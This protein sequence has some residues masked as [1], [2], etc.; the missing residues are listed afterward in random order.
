MDVA[1]ASVN[2]A[3][4]EEIQKV[5]RAWMGQYRDMSHCN[6]TIFTDCNKLKEYFSRCV[7]Q[8]IIIDTNVAQNSGIEF[9]CELRK[10][11]KNFFLLFVSDNADLIYDSFVAEPIYFLNKKHLFTDMKKAMDALVKKMFLGRENVPFV[12]KVG[13]SNKSMNPKNIVYI[14]KDKNALVFITEK[15]SQ[16]KIRGTISQIEEDLKPYNF[17]KIECGCLV[18]LFYVSHIEGIQLYLKNGTQLY[19]SRRNKHLVE[20]S[21]YDYTHQ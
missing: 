1:I 5:F 16:Y 6:I 21:F 17:V 11:F 15:G 3:A 13:V 14:Y 4:G 10:C 2:M 8:V 19:I 9:A 7:F 20:Q 12:W 18:N